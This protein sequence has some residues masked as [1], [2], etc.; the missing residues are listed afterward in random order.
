MSDIALVVASNRFSNSRQ[1]PGLW[2]LSINCC[3]RKQRDAQREIEAH[4]SMHLLM[5][6]HLGEDSFPLVADSDKGRSSLRFPPLIYRVLLQRL[7]YW[8]SDAG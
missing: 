7:W 2:K 6:A 5:I 4:K 8:H 1:G 3:P